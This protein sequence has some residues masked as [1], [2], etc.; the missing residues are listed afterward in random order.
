MARRHFAIGLRSIEEELEIQVRCVSRLK[1]HLL[2]LEL[3]D[4]LQDGECQ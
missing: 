4:G 3:S 1:V 2:R